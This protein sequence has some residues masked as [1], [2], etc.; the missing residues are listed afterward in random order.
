MISEPAP[1]KDEARAIRAVCLGLASPGQQRIAM[2]WIINDLCRVARPSYAES[3]TETA[4][5]EGHRAVGIVL[6]DLAGSAPALIET[7]DGRRRDPEDIAAWN[8]ARGVPEAPDKYTITAKAPEGV[9]VPEQAKQTLGVINDRLHK[10]GADTATVN[11]A[12]ELFYEQLAAET[13]V[14]AEVQQ[15]AHA[16]CEAALKAKWRGADY[17]TNVQSA[18]RVLVQ[19]A[20]Q[21]F[22]DEFVTRE[23]ADGSRLGDDPNLITFLAQLGLQFRE[24]PGFGEAPA[25]AAASLKEEIKKIMD[26]RLT[27]EGTRDYDKPETQARLAKLIEQRDRQAA[28]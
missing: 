14:R 25:V 12:H 16:A 28:R 20:G 11:A 9:E 3:P 19:F 15:A 18:N 5:N 1:T 8:K 23:M 27:D 24:D 17:E 22:A 21:E 4:F 7:D 26:L 6:F 10:I 2:R 13:A